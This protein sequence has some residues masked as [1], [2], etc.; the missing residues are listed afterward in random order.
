MNSRL[1]EVLTI[2]RTVSRMLVFFA[3]VSLLVAILGQYA[4]TAFNMRR[5]TREFG[6]R[7]A[8]GRVNT[9]SAAGG[10]LRDIANDSR[11]APAWFRAQPGGRSRGPSCALWRD[12]DGPTHL[13]RCGRRTRHRLGDRVLPSGLAGR[14]GKRRRGVTAGI[15]AVLHEGS[16]QRF[17]TIVPRGSRRGFS[18]GFCDEP[19]VQNSVVAC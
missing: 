7:L 3:V 5:R 19:C 4:M 2:E 9:S 1:D 12:A 13:R 8:L 14:A 10:D 17:F 16:S 6:V 11:R 18:T 15:D